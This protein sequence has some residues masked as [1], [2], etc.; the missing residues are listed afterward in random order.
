MQQRGPADFKP[1]PRLI[2][3]VC[4]LPDEP[5]GRP[6]YGPLICFLPYRDSE[7]NDNVNI[8]GREEAVKA[9]PTSLVF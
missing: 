5:P 4:A 6:L 3:V 2:L 8:Q 7:H 1:G 9:G